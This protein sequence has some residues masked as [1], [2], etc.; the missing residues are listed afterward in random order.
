MRRFRDILAEKMVTFNLVL[1]PSAATTSRAGGS[2]TTT[3]RL[4]PDALRRV[5]CAGAAPRWTR[6]RLGDANRYQHSDSAM[7]HLLD[8]Q[9]ALGIR[10]VNYGP[11][12]DAALIRAKMPD[13]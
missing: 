2:P 5:L 9:Y 1:A 4:Q 11:E 7:G 13:A 12:V 10:E 3:A 6:L 8:Q